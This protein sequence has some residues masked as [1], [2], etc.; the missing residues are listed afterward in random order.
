M[1]S[2]PVF[3]L[4]LA[5]RSTATYPLN[6]ATTRR[7]PSDRLQ[8]HPIPGTHGNAARDAVDGNRALGSAGPATTVSL[9]E[10]SRLDIVM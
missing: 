6:S 8:S 9:V 5:D 2:S 3:G 7:P 1:L 4:L 10:P